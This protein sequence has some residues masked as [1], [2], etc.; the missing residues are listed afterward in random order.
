LSSI[1]VVL[2]LRGGRVS[3]AVFRR[4]FDA[5][6]DRGPDGDGRWVHGPVGL[7]QQ[8]LALTP[9][10]VGETQP[11][12][13][14]DLVGVFD[15]RLDNREELIGS[16]FVAP[17]EGRVVTDAELIV[18]AFERW[19]D[20]SVRHLLGDFCLAVWDTG[21]EQLYCARDHLGVRPLYYADY[22]GVL[23]IA[24]DIRGVLAHPSVVKEPNK[25]H[26]AEILLEELS[27]ET[28]TLYERVVR[29]PPAHLLRARDGRIQVERY[30]DVD[31]NKELHYHDDQDYVDAF[32]AVFAE[33]VRCR[34]RCR[35]EATVPL[36]GGLDS[37]LIAAVASDLVKDRTAAAPLISATSLVFP[38][39]ACDESEWITAVV[40]HIGL[41]SQQ[42][43]WGP[44][45]WEKVLEDA[46]RTAYLPPYPNTTLDMFV[47]GGVTRMSVINGFGGDQWMAGNNTHFYDLWSDRRSWLL[48]MN[49]LQGGGSR[50][51][52]GARRASVNRLRGYLDRRPGERGPSSGEPPWMGPALRGHALPVGSP[53]LP[54]SGEVTRAKRRC[55]H[56]LHDTW[57]P[58]AFEMLDRAAADGD[59]ASTEPFYDRRVVEF[60]CALP[61]SQRWHGSDNRWLER[62]A[63]D[64]LLP[65]EVVERR[66]KAEFTEPFAAQAQ[67]LGLE[68]RLPGFRTVGLGWVTLDEGTSS[69]GAL[70]GSPLRPRRLWLIAAVEAW[71]RTVWG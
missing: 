64:G 70:A 4:V 63:L 13:I 19:R 66:S 32:K 47:R 26:V 62:R 50:L 22:G 5:I 38:G 56:T 54:A 1:A 9:E 10:E 12:V 51:V 37:S 28:D 20:D 7:G 61:E 15:G 49:V 43:P 57:T 21:R 68:R 11:V 53:A 34:L 45:T 31:L 67:A 14:G 16:L 17:P 69:G 52:R 60:A 18:R 48:A 25:R 40:S 41:N 24:T 29:L 44:V 65:T 59:L 58:H 8:S 30:W 33:A 2:N 27:N 71:V 6:E 3:E 36:S 39:M 46:E 55:Y 35:S 42:I 23:V